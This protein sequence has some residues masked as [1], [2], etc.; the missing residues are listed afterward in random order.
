M[1]VSDIV[2]LPFEWGSAIRGK[3]FFHPLGVLAEGSIERTAPEGEGLPIPS[4]DVVARVS[5]ATGTPGAL[6]DLIGLAIRVTPPGAADPWDILLV[7]SGSGVLSRAVALRPVT[8]WAGHTLTTL[9]GLHYEGRNW[10]LRVRIVTDIDGLGL[11][12]DAVRRRIEE[13]GVEVTLDQ[14]CGRGD[15][16]PLGRLTLTRMLDGEQS[17]DPV[18]NTAPGVSLSPGWLA[19]LRASAYQRSRDGRDAQ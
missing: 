19:S 11:S 10:W 6:P 17:F 5:K 15:F 8:S 4:S 1:N 14:A 7:S 12:L 2:A 9:M 18:V 16:T 3:R 13:D